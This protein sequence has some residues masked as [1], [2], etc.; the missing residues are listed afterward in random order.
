MSERVAVARRARVEEAADLAHDVDVSA[1]AVAAYGV[2]LARS[3][4]CGDRAQRSGVVVHM[5]PVAHVFTVAVYRQRLFAERALNRE[6]NQLFGKLV[7]TVIVRAV[8]DDRGQSVG[9]KPGAHQVIRSGLACRI[10]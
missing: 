2:R 6:R 9:V 8:A 1:L 3:S 5:E 4:T 10:R 7:R